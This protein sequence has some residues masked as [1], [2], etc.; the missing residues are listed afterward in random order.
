MGI[1]TRIIKLLKYTSLNTPY[2]SKKYK[3]LEKSV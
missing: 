1:T 2:I 3:D